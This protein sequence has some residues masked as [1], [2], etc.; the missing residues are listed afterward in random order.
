MKIGRKIALPMP[1]NMEDGAEWSGEPVAGAGRRNAEGE[2][3]QQL[4][5]HHVAAGRQVLAVGPG[6]WQGPCRISRMAGRGE[7]L[8]IGC[9][10]RLTGPSMACAKAFMPAGCR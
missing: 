3:G 5:Q 4:G 6:T 8:R 2:S 1:R 10:S 9:V 7:D